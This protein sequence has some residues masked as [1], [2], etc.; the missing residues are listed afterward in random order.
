MATEVRICGL[1]SVCTLFAEPTW[2]VRR[3]KQAAQEATGV[4]AREL[5]LLTGS[6]EHGEL[7]R[8]GGVL[9]ARGDVACGA[10]LELSCVRRCPEQARWLE[11]VAA[12][13]TGDFL[14]EA[15]AHVRADREVVL[16]AV[17]Q[18]G[19]ALA[20]ACD[21][22]RG[23][24]EVVLLAL[25]DRED[26]D[27]LCHDQDAARDLEAGCPRCAVPPPRGM[28]RS[29]VVTVFGPDA[30]D[31]I[32][33]DE[34][35][36]GA[37]CGVRIL[38]ALGRGALAAGRLAPA[39]R[40][41]FAAVRAGALRRQRDCSVAGVSRRACR[42]KVCSRMGAADGAAFKLKRKLGGSWI[43]RSDAGGAFKAPPALFGQGAP[44]ETALSITCGLCGNSRVVEELQE[45][46]GTTAPLV[47]TWRWQLAEETFGG[48]E[49]RIAS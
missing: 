16:A 46:P 35:A 30:G 7:E 45:A 34:V 24:R 25:E 28:D 42:G 11:A 14:G 29:D 40:G 49:C 48:K 21:E 44:F 1:G 26:P 27:A 41:R 23:D 20:H 22:L 4:P 3:L 43:W 39:K 18:N 5:R 47:G 17:A 32:W 6:R 8:L 33:F 36:S 15:P 19:R 12:D 31:C 13:A 9:S 2:T 38:G 37:Q 10:P